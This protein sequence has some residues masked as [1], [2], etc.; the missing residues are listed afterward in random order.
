[1]EHRTTRG[2]SGDFESR[3]TV[4]WLEVGIGAVVGHIFMVLVSLKQ[5][6]LNNVKLTG[7]N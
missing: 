7:G 5:S 6:I 4:G 3:S 2:W 1:M